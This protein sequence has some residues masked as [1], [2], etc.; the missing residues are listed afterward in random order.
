MIHS[1][2]LI[3][4]SRNIIIFLIFVLQEDWI[5]RR[6]FHY[7]LPCPLQPMLFLTRFLFLPPWALFSLF[8]SIFLLLYIW[9]LFFHRCMQPSL[10][11]YLP[12][13][14]TSRALPGISTKSLFERVRGSC[15]AFAATMVITSKIAIVRATVIINLSKS[16]LE[17]KNEKMKKKK[18][19]K[20]RIDWLRPSPRCAGGILHRMFHSENGMNIFRPH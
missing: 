5:T 1:R 13:I 9:P 15:F 20:G 8:S 12:T 6:L 11:A 18:K 7:K 10:A 14:L 3:T 19:R 17:K 16:T 4:H 2:V